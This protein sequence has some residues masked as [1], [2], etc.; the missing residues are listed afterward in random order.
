MLWAP[1][2]ASAVCVVTKDDGRQYTDTTVPSCAALY[3]ERHYCGSTENSRTTVCQQLNAM[4]APDWNGSQDIVISP[5]RGVWGYR[6]PAGAS[7]DPAAFII[8]SPDQDNNPQ[9]SLHSTENAQVAGYTFIELDFVLNW[10]YPASL[11]SGTVMLSHFFDLYG[12][13]DYTG[14]SVGTS[15]GEGFLPNTSPSALA[16][17]DLTLRST[18]T[19]QVVTSS[20]GTNRLVTLDEFL[21]YIKTLSPIPIIVIDPKWAKKY[22]ATPRGGGS[23]VC[24]W[25]CNEPFLSETSFYKSQY[26]EVLTQV[27]TRASVKGLLPNIIVKAP[28]KM[29]DATTVESIPHWYEV[30]WSP[31]P[32]INTTFEDNISY[33]DGWEHIAD[34]V[35]FVEAV[36]PDEH[37]WAANVIQRGRNIYIDLSD[38]IKKRY[39]KRFG[40]WVISEQAQ[41]GSA[42]SYF[43]GVLW[44]GSFPGD[45]K[46]EFIWST[47]QLR[48]G[49]YSVVTTDQPHIYTNIRTIIDPP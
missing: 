20:M 34:S 11:S 37:N 35:A 2:P 48:W 43:P 49:R 1:T 21:D 15:T 18:L 47:E 10:Q 22:S 7:T 24:V 28:R 19:R 39:D 23:P 6:L 12:S 17:M 8:I 30:L 14:K 26:M 27:L 36:V 4:V 16:R 5:H 40:V 45:R 41:W 32:D 3:D 25:F 46:G 13:T 42:T 31:Q 38:Y 29:I 44:L 33:L 9:N